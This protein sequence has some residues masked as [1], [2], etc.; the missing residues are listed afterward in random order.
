ML[1]RTVAQVTFRI[2]GRL[3]ALMDGRRVDLSSRRERALLG[4]LLLNLGEVVS[5]DA[6]IDSVWGERAPASARHLVHEYV[7]RIRAAFGDGSLI[8]TRAPGYAVEHDS[9]ELDTMRFA[10]L[11]GRARSA[12]AA[13]DLDAALPAFEE[14]LGLWR[15]DVLCDL[16]LEGDARAAA[17]RLD[18]QRRA[19]QSE[20]V[21][22]ALA[23]G[24][25]HQLIPDL[26][27]AVAA[28]PLDEQLR[29]QLML[30]LYR[31]GRQADALARFREGRHTLVEQLGIEPG[32]ELRA[33]EQAILRH[34][35]AL[36]L[37]APGETFPPAPPP[38]RRRRVAGLAAAAVVVIAGVATIVAVA[39]R[40]SPSAVAPVRGDAV[41]V[42]DAV[43]ARLLGS[44]PVT[45]PP[46]AIVHGAGAVW[47]SLPAA[48]SV[49][50]ISPESRQVAATFPL[51]VAPQ[52]LAVAGSALWALGSGATDPFMTLERIDPTFGSVSAVR[53]LPVV[54][55]GDR[56]S[57]SARGNT[58]LVAP[59]TGLLRRID[60]RNGHTL[61][62]LNPNAAPSAAALG[63]G[64]SWL[65]YRDADLVLRV[66]SSGAIKPIPVG[67]GPSAIA[68]GKRA[69]WVANAIDGTVKSI[70]PA[71]GAVITTIRVGSDPTAV[72]TDGDSVWVANG[73]DGTLTRIDERT[74][75]PTARVTVGGSPQAL[76]VADGK[77]W[78]SVQPPAAAK[79]SGGTAVV[80]VPA[81]LTNLDPG[82][83][84]NGPASV[85]EYATC[86][87]LLSFPDEAGPG[88]LR[89][90]PD[91][92]RSLP[93]VSKDGRAYTFTIR[94]GLRFSPPSNQPVTA[95][96]FKHA[97]ERSANP[98]MSVDRHPAGQLFLRDV[99]GAPAYMAGQAPHIAGIE[100]RGDRLT[101]HLTERAPDL[102]ARM[103]V[104]LY[105]AVPTDTPMRPLSDPIPTAG[106]YYVASATPGKS[107]VLLRNPNYHGDRPRRLQRI[108]IVVG[109]SHPVA[110]I[111]ASKLDYTLAP[112]PAGAS[113]RLE[114][115]YGAHSAAARRGRQRF[116]AS[117]GAVVDYVNLNTRRPLFA[118]ARMR[119]AVA[120][121]VDR[122]ALAAT[123]GAFSTAAA[124][125]QMSIPPGI[126]GF[127][128]RH[129][130]PLVP[131]LARARRLAG[132]GHHE[133]ELYC[134]LEGGGPKAAQVV[135]NNLAAIGID[136][137]VHCMPGDDFYTRLFRPNEP[138]DMD[139]E[140]YGADYPDPGEFIDGL[141]L[142]DTFNLS[143]YHDA[144]LSRRIR[145]ASRLS[146]VARAEAY[147]K[148]DLT[149]TRDVVPRV[150]FANGVGQDFFSARIG[151]QLFQP[152][153]GIDL[154]ALCVRHTQ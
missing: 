19:V 54:V 75:R 139:I 7:S 133:A 131:D 84:F 44:V 62:Q 9:C 25:H 5:A 102:P 1:L 69:V 124:P 116:F 128:D 143:H 105:C 60:A 110:Q 149:V 104:P 93:T 67:R 135:K 100:A 134:V 111:E 18:D 153:E 138:W 117:R 32:A 20:R 106:P 4:V 95:Q 151:C 12:V 26:E 50:R 3:E 107:F 146:G 35:P 73:G 99:V 127:R 80:N 49:I 16:A 132:S 96:S 66:D 78:A 47:V 48:R 22:V 10:R 41:A 71:T 112:L 56:G 34:D 42:V 21:E 8:V 63:F 64:S 33:L 98:H 85:V 120:Y 17:A 137:H 88:G 15:G 57:L 81:F 51:G 31:D 125:A 77:V 129:V 27:R 79:P 14:A 70:D 59:R 43:H 53:R 122:R 82:Q 144:G 126:P 23:V 39:A 130:Y 147:A 141:A 29:R 101:I 38:A 152:V 136:V 123:G 13:S 74:N 76:A 40:K 58:L 121:A 150:N 114:R 37:P 94:P 108:E 61:G 2:L 28:E 145:A 91:A 140:S 86:A 6:L 115:L 92:A 46:G 72:A 103:T 83:Q 118:S 68:V 89:L 65:A 24:R 148:L 55:G 113:A 119:R 30:A 154:A 87:T 90:V 142:D 52:S 45:T 97:I 109:A 11:V 36:A